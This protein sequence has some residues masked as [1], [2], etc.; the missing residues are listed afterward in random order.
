MIR[1]HA[2]NRYNHTRVG[3]WAWALQRVTGVALVLYLLAHIGVISTAV[4]GEKTFDDA[5]AFL[6]TPVFIVL[7]LLL[8]AAVV[9]HTVNG[10]RVILFDLGVGIRHQASAGWIVMGFTLGVTV[11]STVVTWPLIFR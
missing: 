6:Q 9:Y 4:A 8:L 1:L 5:L 3:W 11:V 10:I 7:D 2:Y